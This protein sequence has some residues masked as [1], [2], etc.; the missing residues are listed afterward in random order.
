M[1]K[2][3]LLSVT[4]STIVI[5]SSAQA[6]VYDPVSQTYGNAKAHDFYKNEGDDWYASMFGAGTLI[7][8]R[9][10]EVSGVHGKVAFNN[11]YGLLFAGGREFNFGTM[12]DL[13]AELELGWRRNGVDSFS[14]AGTSYQADGHMDAYSL[15]G[16][17]YYDI[18]TQSNFTPYIGFGLGVADVQA[19][20]ITT[21][22][23]AGNIDDDDTVFAYQGMLGLDY[24]LGYQWS[25]KGEYRYFKTSEL[26]YTTSA[27]APASIKYDNNGLLLGASYKF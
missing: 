3:L 9:G 13:R 19:N 11:G 5:S 6:Q 15:M 26:D 22:A 24:A 1:K 10:A 18:K 4:A 27:G 2:L 21:P 7:N 17:F 16:N 23:V 14:F 20:N 8:D 12:V 25:L